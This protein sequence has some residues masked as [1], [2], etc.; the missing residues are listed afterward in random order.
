MI[1]E[2][3][4]FGLPGHSGIGGSFKFSVFWSAVRFALAV[5]FSGSMGVFGAAAEPLRLA[6]FDVDATPPLGY[7]MAYDPVVRVDAMTLRCRG[8]V[9]LSLIHI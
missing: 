3:F 1:Y 8:V 4:N 5:L 2:R 7:M 9:L 6:T